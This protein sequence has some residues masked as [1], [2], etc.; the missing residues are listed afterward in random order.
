MSYSTIVSFAAK[1]YQVNV[2]EINFQ[3]IQYCDGFIFIFNYPLSPN[4]SETPS[5]EDD[6][7]EESFHPSVIDKSIIVGI[8]ILQEN[9]EFKKNLVNH[10]SLDHS[11]AVGQNYS[12]F[13]DL[14]IFF[15]KG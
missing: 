1:Y 12:N 4:L 14:L 9:A 11:D 8:F 10:S 3:Q 5:L 6:E 15:F 2:E 13:L 7:C